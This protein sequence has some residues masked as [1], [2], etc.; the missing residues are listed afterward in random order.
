MIV[1]YEE[2]FCKTNIKLLKIMIILSECKVRPFNLSECEQ[3]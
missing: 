3:R 2:L 1:K